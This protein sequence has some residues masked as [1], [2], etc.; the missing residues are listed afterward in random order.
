MSPTLSVVLVAVSASQQRHVFANR[1]TPPLK[2]YFGVSNRVL[3]TDCNDDATCALTFQGLGF[4]DEGDGVCAM[5]QNDDSCTDWDSA[6][7]TVICEECMDNQYSVSMLIMGVVTDWSSILTKFQRSTEFGDVS[8]QKFM[9]MVG[10]IIGI[11]T[12]I[13]VLTGYADACYSRWTL[14]SR[15]SP[16]RQSSPP[17]SSARLA[18]SP[19]RVAR[20]LTTF[21]D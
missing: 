4:S 3:A 11:L 20:G 21:G 14:E 8:C 16:L 18:Y 13:T 5:K 12:S 1:N 9:G 19:R 17:F 2:M 7:L 10:T 6:T 15:P